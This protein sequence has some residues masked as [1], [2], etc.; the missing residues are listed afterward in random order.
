MPNQ[1]TVMNIH[2]ILSILML[3]LLVVSIVLK[4][5]LIDNT[6]TDNIV[7]IMKIIIFIVMGSFLEYFSN[8]TILLIGG[9]LS[10]YFIAWIRE[11]A[12]DQ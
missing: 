3:L 6:I 2:F 1:E 4:L 7:G 9:F 8:D 5:F 12:I 11:K 10:G